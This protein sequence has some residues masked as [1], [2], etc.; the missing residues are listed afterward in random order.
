MTHNARL[1]SF[2]DREKLSRKLENIKKSEGMLKEASVI[3]KALNVMG[4]EML[5]EGMSAPHVFQKYPHLKNEFQKGVLANS[6]LLM[7]DLSPFS[8]LVADWAPEDISIFL[9]RYYRIVVSRVVDVGGVVEKYIGD[10]VVA[11][12]G[13]PFDQFTSPGHLKRV[14]NLS[15]TLVEEI[16]SEFQGEVTA[17]CAI[18]YGSCHYGYLGPSVHS[19]LTII[20]TPLTELFRLEADCPARSVVL[21][22]ALFENVEEQYQLIPIDS[23]DPAGVP[24]IYRVETKDLRGVGEVDVVVLTLES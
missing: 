1:K 11:A 10:A 18:A 8:S 20:G 6:L 7:I 9:E 23:P 13:A 2:V 5:K 19:E 4:P 15:R 17:K 16:E 3:T 24:W 14:I 22:E 12:F 21:L